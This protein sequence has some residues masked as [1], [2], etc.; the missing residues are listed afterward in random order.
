MS[1]TP[2][3]LAKN[4]NLDKIDYTGWLVSIKYD[5][6][7]LF[8]KDG[9]ALTRGLK[10]Y[11]MPDWLL[12]MIPDNIDGEAYLGKDFDQ[13][14]ALRRQD[15]ADN[16]WKKVKIL[17]FDQVRSDN[18]PYSVKGKTEDRFGNIKKAAKNCKKKYGKKCPLVI[19]KQT[20]AKSN[21]HI[22]KLFK[23][24]VDNGEEGVMLRNPSTPYE[25]KR[26][27]NLAKLKMEADE[28]AII[29]GYTKGKGKNKDK[30]GAWKC[31]MISQDHK[32]TGITFKLA[33]MNDK[34]RDFK[35][36]LPIGTVLTF[37]HRGINPKSGKPRMPT[38]MRVRKDF[39][40]KK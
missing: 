30:V 17:V 7:R 3:T 18:M 34:L 37:R 32:L 14:G 1:P 40:I 4:A 2:V 22:R 24:A 21:D 13:H 20:V 38:F 16:V 26:T 28:E 11:T 10:K 39:K 29:L 27:A 19:V 9:F 25:K 12:E 23:K 31:E 15:D 33:G 5:G 6:Y 36:T 35:S 8:T